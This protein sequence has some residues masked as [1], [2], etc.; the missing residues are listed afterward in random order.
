MNQSVQSLEIDS[1]VKT[2][3]FYSSKIWVE[4]KIIKLCSPSMHVVEYNL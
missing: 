1:A 2:M 3:E 4:L